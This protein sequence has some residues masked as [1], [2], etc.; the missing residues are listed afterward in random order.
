[1]KAVALARV[2]EPIPEPIDR[3]IPHFDDLPDLCTPDEASR[4]LRIKKKTL[5]E[6][7]KTGAVPSL[8]FGRLLRIPKRS[9]LEGN[10]Q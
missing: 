1:M 2:L 4:F 7:I 10:H 9:L 5:Y 3:S 6:L 8:R